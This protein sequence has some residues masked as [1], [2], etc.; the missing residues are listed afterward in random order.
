MSLTATGRSGR[1]TWWRVLAPSPGM[2]IG[3]ALFVALLLHQGIERLAD[4][5]A[6]AG[7]GILVLAA[8]HTTSIFSDAIAWR[9]LIDG[10]RRP[11][12]T[13][14]AWT[15][16]IGESVNALLPV[17]QIGGNIVRARDMARRGVAAPVAGASVVVDVTLEALT[18]FAFALIGLGLLLVG[19]RGTGLLLPTVVGAGTMF[20]LVGAF[21]LAQRLGLFGAAV[22]ALRRM[23]GPENWLPDAAGADELDAQV[24]RTYGN[25]AGVWSGTAW[26]LIGWTCG[27]GEVWLALRFLGHPVD[28]QSAFILESLGSAVRAAAFAVPGAIGVQEGGLVVLGGVLGLP[29]DLCIALSLAKRARE[30]L[31]G[32][33]GLI[34]WQLGAA[35]ARARE[36][37][38]EE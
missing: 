29:P 7:W 17:M 18:Q 19:S 12:L 22:R 24:V 32:V 27:V 20:L 10:R 37:E 11:P 31:L 2:L 4:E 30:I 38:E 8:Y 6:V 13:A 5:L 16:W 15:R 14:L 1:A 35:R 34:A 36:E 23:G 25:R 28:L 21:A 9:G 33:P 3:I 26:H